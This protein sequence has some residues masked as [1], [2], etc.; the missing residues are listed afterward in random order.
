MSINVLSLS[1]NGD[2]DTLLFRLELLFSYCIAPTLIAQVY[3]LRTEPDCFGLDLTQFVFAIVEIPAQLN[4]LAHFGR[5]ISQAG[6]LL[7]EVAAC[8]ALHAFQT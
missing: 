8:F 3:I 7:F 2:S 6:F 5:R 4:S 1:T